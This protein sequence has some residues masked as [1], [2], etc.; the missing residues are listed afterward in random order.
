MG[1][2]IYCGRNSDA[3]IINNVI[4]LNYSENAGGGIY[5]YECSPVIKNNV[6]IR[7]ESDA[8][9]G[10]LF[11]NHANPTIV[12]NSVSGN[13][14]AG[15]AGGIIVYEYSHATIINTICWGDTAGETVNEIGLYFESSVS[16]SFSNIG[17]S[18][19][20]GEGNISVDP[21]F[22]DPDNDDYH[23]MSTACGDLYDSPCIDAGDPSIFDYLL[24]CD[25]GLGELRSDMGAYGGQA[26][27]TDIAEEREPTIP[28]A[29]GL[30]QNYP[31]P[32]N[33]TTTLSYMLPQSRSVTI[34]VYNLLGQRVATIF[35]GNR[36]AGRHIITW[37]AAAFPSGVYFARLE[38]G[39]YSRSIKMVL[40][41]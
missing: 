32:F 15:S 4:M 35:D 7:N 37:D 8:G 20:P 18:L 13:I 24:D 9:G 2:G 16:I 31:N 11:F 29:C 23:L 3:L 21:L 40:L 28:M 25:W 14:D 26:I 36:Q 22:R 39:E 19:W 5:C 10:G 34:S 33:A 12:N 27:P 38:A 1:G 41:K 17:D 30:L 6:I